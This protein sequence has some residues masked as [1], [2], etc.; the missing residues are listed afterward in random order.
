MTSGF[1][2]TW[3]SSFERGKSAACG[4]SIHQISTLVVGRFGLG[5]YPSQVEA[6]LELRK[7]V[8]EAILRI[9][10]NAPA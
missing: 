4:R 5:K 6:E 2:T 9:G 1:L 7:L 3:L 8:N 10:N